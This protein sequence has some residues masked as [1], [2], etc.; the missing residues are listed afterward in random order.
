MDSDAEQARALGQIAK[1]GTYIQFLIAHQQL[2]QLPGA[3]PPLNNA[4]LLEPR[5]ADGAPPSILI[6]CIPSTIDDIPLPPLETSEDEARSD[7]VVDYNRLS[8]LS[9]KGL[10]L[11]RQNVEQVDKP[12]HF[13]R[14]DI[15][16][17]VI[18]GQVEAEG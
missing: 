1:P 2:D 12:D 14:V 4:E 15:P 7:L 17:G 8:I 9:E 6:G 3:A 10:Y 11:R 5:E 13:T 16:G 18:K